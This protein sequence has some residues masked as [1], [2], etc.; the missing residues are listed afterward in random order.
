LKKRSKGKQN[1]SSKKQR[2]KL[3]KMKATTKQKMPAIV[4]SEKKAKP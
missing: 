3:K 1:T 2:N 4:T